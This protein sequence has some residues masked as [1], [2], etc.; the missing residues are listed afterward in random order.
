MLD[1]PADAPVEDCIAR[2]GELHET[3]RADYQAYYDRN[4]TP[5]SPAIRGADPLI[6]LV[7]GVGMFSY[8]ARQADRPGG[9]RVLSER[10]QRD[11][12]R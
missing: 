7:P 2:L 12:R 4:A 6:I 10:D 8:G 1:L 5:D 9:W 11:A 3:Y